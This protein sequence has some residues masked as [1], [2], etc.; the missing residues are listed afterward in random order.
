MVRKTLGTLTI[1]VLVFGVPLWAR[2]PHKAH[3]VTAVEMKNPA[4]GLVAVDCRINDDERSYVCLIDSGATRTVISDRV[5][6]AEGTLVEINTAA[7]AI[8]GHLREV[9]LKIADGLELKSKAVVESNPMPQDVDILLG[10]DILRQFHSVV[11][12]YRNR[13]VEFRR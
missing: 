3:E 4:L 7:G 2:R 13:T 12:D 8:H 9:S 10:Q 1:A 5:L 6:K 11:F